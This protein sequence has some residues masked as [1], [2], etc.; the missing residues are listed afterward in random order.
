M[1]SAHVRVICEALGSGTL[2]PKELKETAEELSSDQTGLIVV[3]EP[4]IEK[5]F[6]QAVS[7]VPPRS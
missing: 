4:T 5:D 6:D 3:G 7:R 1:D 2:R